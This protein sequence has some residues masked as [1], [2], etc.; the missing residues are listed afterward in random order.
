MFQRIA[1][2]R[3]QISSFFQHSRTPVVLTLDSLRLKRTAFVA[4]AE[5]GLK[6]RLKPS[7]GESFTFYENLIRR[8]YLSRGITLNEG[9][10][11]VDI[12]ANIGAFAVLAASIVGPK[13][14]VIA[15]EPVAGTFERLKENVALNKLTNVECHRAAIDREEGTVT[16]RV[17]AKSAL[18][19][20]HCF[21]KEGDNAATETVPCHT[22]DR[23]FEDHQIERINLLK[24]D[25][26]GG[27]HGIFETLT[28]GCAARIDQIAMEVHQVKGRSLEQLGEKLRALG[29]ELHCGSVWVAFNAAV[30]PPKKHLG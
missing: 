20:A 17:A 28:P 21:D 22:L 27:E 3:Q 5:G 24:V 26:E 1:M 18:S 7:A 13:G 11:V 29:F 14:R 8:D 25:C 12:G 4:V 23:I 9:S 30:S 2:K 15:Y 6:L 10:T 16:I 19:T